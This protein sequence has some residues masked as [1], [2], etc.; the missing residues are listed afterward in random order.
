MPKNKALSSHTHTATAGNEQY[1]GNG[2]VASENSVLVPAQTGQQ[3]VALD[4]RRGSNFDRFDLAVV[5][6]FVLACL[7][8]AHLPFAPH[9]L[10]DGD[11][12]RAA[13][14]LS[15]AL[16][17]QCAWHDVE[18][19]RLPGAVAYYAL[20]YLAVSVNAS[21]K[22]FWYVGVIWN[23]FWMGIATLLVRRAGDLLGGPLAGKAAAALSLL[24]PFSIYYSF[25]IMAETPA[26]LGGAVLA[27]G[28]IAWVRSVRPYWHHVALTVTGL[29]LMLLSRTNIVLVFPIMFVCGLIQLRQLRRSDH[30]KFI[31]T[32]I[33]ITTVVFSLVT[34]LM[35]LLPE[36][37]RGA[38]LDN[39]LDVTMQGRFQFRTDHW[40]WRFWTYYPGRADYIAYM[41][42][43]QSLDMASVRTGVPLAKLQTA[44]ILN[45]LRH[46]PV[47]NL[48]M[49]GV[50][51]LSIHTA[52]VNSK[53]ASTF[54]LGPFSGR[55]VYVI[56]HLLLNSVNYLL[57]LFSA[58]FLIRERR[59]VALY[60]SL[61]A[62]WLALL[63]FHCVVYAEPRY[64]MPARPGLALMG[65][66]VAAAYLS[67]HSR[68]PSSAVA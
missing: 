43:V 65:G 56:F 9:P 39:L 28:A 18:V 61:W 12:Y 47:A 19:R 64:L 13:R 31:T 48:E 41:R 20:P 3:S 63:L 23:L 37:K 10:G 1:T 5:G 21:Q 16:K 36:S 49:F 35:L 62:P 17:G 26:Y 32:C 27:Y 22:T 7:L 34:M 45:D 46:H 42:T 50:R 51:L 29:S 60:W 53:P 57:V 59:T 24:S 25:G 4:A 6:V 44:W 15:C 14:D 11:F 55:V 58:R 40:D 52:L 68:P 66:M 54:K 8:V 33:I 2:L 67:R 30:L 38:Q